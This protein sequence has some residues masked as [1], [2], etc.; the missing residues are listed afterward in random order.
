ML[1]FFEVRLFLEKRKMRSYPLMDSYLHCLNVQGE[2]LSFYQRNTEINRFLLRKWAQ[3]VDGYFQYITGLDL[4][5]PSWYHG[6][7]KLTDKGRVSLQG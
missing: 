7:P 2:T 1:C 3:Y 6:F 5:D 4:I